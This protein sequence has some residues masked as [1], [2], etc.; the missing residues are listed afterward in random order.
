MEDFLSKETIRILN[1]AKNLSH[2]LNQHMKEPEELEEEFLTLFKG[3]EVVL[4]D[5]EGET[6]GQLDDMNRYRIEL[7][8]E[9][10]K[11]FFNKNNLLGYYAKA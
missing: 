7:L 8:V 2:A 6:Q 9:G 10:K 1:E 3:K 4:M 5:R 11:R